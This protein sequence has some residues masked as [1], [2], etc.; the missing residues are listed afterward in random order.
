MIIVAALDWQ[1]QGAELT[2]TVNLSFATDPTT[3]VFLGG[4]VGGDYFEAAAV[5][6]NGYQLTAGQ[7]LTV[8]SQG[9]PRVVTAGAFHTYNLPRFQR[10]LDFTCTN[11]A[12][13]AVL[14]FYTTPRREWR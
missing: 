14:T 13:L 9:Q 5:D 11:I 10:Y 6:I 1:Q 8:D 7:V 2:A 4:S 3:R 12:S